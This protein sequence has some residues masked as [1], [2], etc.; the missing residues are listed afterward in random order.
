MSS[1][2]KK[3]IYGGVL[4][5]DNYQYTFKSVIKIGLHNEKKVLYYNKGDVGCRTSARNKLE[6]ICIKNNFNLYEE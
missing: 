4:K 1:K 5:E 6:Q 3:C 2:C